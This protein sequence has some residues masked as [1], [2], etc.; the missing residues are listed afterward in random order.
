[1]IAASGKRATGVV[2]ALVLIGSLL[3]VIYVWRVVEVAYFREPVAGAA[4]PVNEAP[5]VMLIPT[6]LVI[7]ARWSSASGRPFRRDSPTR[8]P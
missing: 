7:G 8:P 1:M 2:A 6:Y 4:G 3:A 5:L